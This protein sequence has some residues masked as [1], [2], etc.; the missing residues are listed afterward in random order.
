[1]LREQSRS[2]L[3]RLFPFRGLPSVHQRNGRN[4]E[5]VADG[6]AI[7][8]RD[9]FIGQGTRSRTRMARST[10]A[11]ASASSATGVESSQ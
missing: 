9:N 6:K 10:P 7:K 11:S 5:N 2:E 1:M 4:A 8:R 3:V